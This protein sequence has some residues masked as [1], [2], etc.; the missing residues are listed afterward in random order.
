M[1][2]SDECD[3]NDD[4][5]VEHVHAVV[6]CMRGAEHPLPEIARFTV[7]EYNATL[8]SSEPTPAEQ[9]LTG[10]YD[11]GFQ[12]LKLLPDD[13]SRGTAAPKIEAPYITYNWEEQVLKIVADGSDP[14]F[15][16]E[17]LVYTLVLADRD[18][19]VGLGGL[20]SERGATFDQASAIGALISGEATFYSDLALAREA[21]YATAAADL[22]DY[23]VALGNIHGDYLLARDVPWDAAMSLFRYY[24][25][26]A[27]ADRRYTEDGPEGV[28][29]GYSEAIA[30]TAYALAGPGEAI[31]AAF[32]AID[33]ALPDPPEG[34]RYLAQDSFGPVMWFMYTARNE[35]DAFD[36][37]GLEEATALAR[38]WIG[39]RI[40]FAGE[41]DGERVAVVWQLADS[42][43]SVAETVVVGSDDETRAIFAELFP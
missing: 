9:A 7:E 6:A 21:D 40:V 34:F 36:G 14:E 25:G 41:A 31:E 20:Y 22:I 8:D 23:G 32:S 35:F 33:T 5:C 29:A 13:W 28:S 2:S 10:Q 26:A 37:P 24:Y 43:G 30:S 16:L 3:V 4:E 38:A 39:D 17:G 19:E 18:A 11:R 15:E 27:A 12:L 1:R 42:D